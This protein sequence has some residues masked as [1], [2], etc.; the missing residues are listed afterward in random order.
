MFED[1][2][3]VAHRGDDVVVGEQHHRRL[4]G[5]RLQGDGR[6]GD[7]P[8]SALAAGQ[9]PADVDLAAG[10][11]V[12]EQFIEVVAG[13]VARQVGVARLDLVGLVPED[14]RD[15][16]VDARLDPRILV[17]RVGPVVE[18][19]DV[20][21]AERRHRPVGEDDLDLLDVA[22]GLLVFQGVRAGRVVADAA[23]QHALV[24]PG[25]VGGVLEAV[26]GEAVVQPRERDPRLCGD[27]FGLGVDLY[28]PVKLLFEVQHDRLVDRLTRQTRPAAAGEHRNRVLGAVLHDRFDVLD[29]RRD[30]DPDRQLVVGARVRCI[31]VPAVGVEADLPLD[32][33]LQVVDEFRLL[34]LRTPV[35]VV[36]PRVVGGIR[37]LVR[38]RLCGLAHDV[39]PN[40][41]AYGV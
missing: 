34:D 40:D 1:G 30:D 29:G 35:V 25:G 2:G 39:N 19:L 9:Q 32:D 28:D 3:D 4:L 24:A 20:H 6:L 17:G 23:A 22:V 11:D 14:V 5:D 16:R 18:L 13:D 33:G 15:D 12:L 41:A 10:L 8:E 36:A 37:R 38:P 31:E 27:R 26:L 7:D 21:P